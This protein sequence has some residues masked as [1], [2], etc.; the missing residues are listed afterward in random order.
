M[1]QLMALLLV[2]GGLAVTVS[3]MLLLSRSLHRLQRAGAFTGLYWSSF[4]RYAGYRLRSLRPMG[5]GLLGILMVAAG[6]ACLYFGM[7]AF[8]ASRLG[9]I[10]G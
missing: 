6:L 7:I 1:P 9:S 10:S 3:G 2:A 5:S 4:R 8:Y